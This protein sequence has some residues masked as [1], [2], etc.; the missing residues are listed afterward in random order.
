M[1]PNILFIMTDQQRFDAL[2][3]HGGLA[4]TPNLDRLAAAGVDLQGHYTQAPVCVPSRCNTF[5][6]RY[7]H[8]HG[9]RE[10]DARLAPTEAHL[11]KVLKQAGY[12]IAYLGKNHL[13]DPVEFDN[14]DLF[15]ECN[16]DDGDA[17]RAAFLSYRAERGRRLA[18]V[19]SWATADFHDHDPV[20]TTPH[21]MRE[22]AIR[23]LRNRTVDQPFFLTLQFA[24]P[25]VPHVAP[26]RFQANYP[27]DAIP[28]PQY[29]ADTLRTKAPRFLIKQE[30]QGALKATDHDKRLY[31]AVYAAMI[32]W[33]DENVGAVLS[34]LEQMGLRGNTIIV[35]TSDHGD[36]AF[37]YGMCKKDLVL[38]DVLLHVPC[39]ISAPG[40]GLKNRPLAGTL[41]E[42]V[43]LTPTLLDLAAIETPYGCQGR[44][45]VD[46]LRGTTEVHRDAVH[47]EICYPDMVNPYPDHETFIRAW[48]EARESDEPHPLKHSAPYNV[49]GDFTKMRRTRDWKYIWYGTGFEE[50]Y[51][52]RTDPDEFHNL[53]GKPEF[54]ERLR[55][56]REEL[57]LWQ[58]RA[59]DP[60]SPL[61]HRRNR[62]RYPAWRS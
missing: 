32:A 22:K 5:T 36:F 20:V 28:L 48:Q 47:A 26:R 9:V 54:A 15:D 33:I 3:C 19:A 17:R 13:F 42:Q 16:G 21:V 27:L 59:E 51:D 29:P 38:L 31:L 39:L 45:M 6:G 55:S 1:K 25:H 40:S 10:N 62:E 56:M 50:L 30:A 18:T 35:F 4:R 44:S 2:S 11:M 12:Q 14:A 23:F 34:E 53:A 61:D 7:P 8:A 52:L 57:L 60:M 41:T 37:D 49:P 24:D 46:L 43:D 58:V